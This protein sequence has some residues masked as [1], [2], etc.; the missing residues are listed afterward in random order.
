MKPTAML[1]LFVCLVVAGCAPKTELFVVLRDVPQDPSFTVI[2]ANDYL[3]QIEFANK[4]E[5]YIISAGVKVVSRP[6]LK[7]VEA[8]KEVGQE[9]AKSGEA[10]G[11]H[12]TLTEKYIAFDET[13]ADYIISTYADSRQIK[14][15]KKTSK[16]IL[17][18]F[19][20]K[21]VKRGDETISEDSL[22]YQALMKLG[23]PVR[24]KVQH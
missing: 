24:Q 20:L 23:I 8:K 11:A 1:L 18:T 5:E 16:E 6:A 2:P 7:E 9:E 15:I 4:V 12:G 21:A 3:Y 14:I 10:K 13:N 19:E 17:S 22:V